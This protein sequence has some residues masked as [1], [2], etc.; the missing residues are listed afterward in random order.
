MYYANIISK[1][2][3]IIF[4][5]FPLTTQAV[6]IRKTPKAS[7]GGKVIKAQI[8]GITCAGQYW[9]ATK[10]TGGFPV[11]GPLVI[12]TTKK[13]ISY[14]SSVLGLVSYTPDMYTCFIPTPTGPVYIPSWQVDTGHFNTSANKRY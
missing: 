3:L 6:T 14:G 5:V 10:P 7:F 1:I 12:D 8:P 9:L 2:I 11:P 4:F 13:K